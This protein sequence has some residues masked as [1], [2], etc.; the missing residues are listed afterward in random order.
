L[1]EARTL[2]LAS[3]RGWLS[4]QYESSINSFRSD[5]AV[6]VGSDDPTAVVRPDQDPKTVAQFEAEARPEKG[7]RWRWADLFFAGAYDSDFMHAL[8]THGEKEVFG[9]ILADSSN[10]E[11]IG[12]C[13][14]A[15]SLLDFM[16]EVFSQ[17]DREVDPRYFDPDHLA[18][19]AFERT[20]HQQTWWPREQLFGAGSRG[21]D[22][23]IESVGSLARGAVWVAV[24]ADMTE[25]LE[26]A[27]IFGSAAAQET[28]ATG[29]LGP[30]F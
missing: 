21:D 11:P 30:D 10:F 9:P 7:D 5:Q 17:G 1:F 19:G 26:P 2:R 6:M 27:A 23:P 25:D 4:S 24:R 20:W 22:R 15:G 16:S 3:E 28:A 12:E 14:G 8:E 13:A 18:G 29:E